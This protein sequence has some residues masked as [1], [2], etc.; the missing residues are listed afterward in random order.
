MWVPEEDSSVVASITPSSS[1][2]TGPPRHRLLH[3]V[4]GG[5]IGLHA[6]LG[7][8]DPGTQLRENKMVVG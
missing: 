8:G 1:T 6:G 7:L 4:V 2:V 3:G 5:A